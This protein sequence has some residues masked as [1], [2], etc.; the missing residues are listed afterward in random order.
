MSLRSIHI[1]HA[2][3]INSLMSITKQTLKR[4]RVSM[5]S[6]CEDGEVLPFKSGRVFASEMS[7]DKRNKNFVWGQKYLSKNCYSSWS[8][9]AIIKTKTVSETTRVGETFI[10]SKFSDLL[11]PAIWFTFTFCKLSNVYMSRLIVV[12]KIWP[13]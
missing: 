13:N 12:V 10:V 11:S 1:S 9:E 7:Y 2:Y 6:T 4:Q 8:T 3:S 5:R